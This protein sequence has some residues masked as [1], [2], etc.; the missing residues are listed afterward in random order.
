MVINAHL[1]LEELQRTFSPEQFA[2]IDKILTSLNQT[3]IINV[4]SDRH[5]LGRIHHAMNLDKYSNNEFRKKLFESLPPNI[6]QNYFKKCKI[7][8]YYSNDE[9]IK[10]V[11][12]FEWGDNLSTKNFIEFF[13]YPNYMIPVTSTKIKSNPL[14]MLFEYQSKIVFDTLNNIEYP[15]SNMLIQMP[16]GTGK[17]RTAIEIICRLFNQN[18]DLQIVWFANNEE[19]LDQAHDTFIDVWN[20]VGLFNDLDIKKFWGNNNIQIVPEKKCVLFAGFQKFH[21]QEHLELCPDYIFVDE[22]HK[23]LAPTYEKIIDDNLNFQKQTRI[24]GLT[25]TPGRGINKEENRRLVDRFNGDIIGI[26]LPE[27]Y[28]DT[29]EDNIIEYLEDQHILAK[30]NCI[31]LKTQFEL[32]LSREEQDYLTGIIKDDF[33]EFSE[34]ILARLATDIP[35]NMLIIDELKKHVNDGKKILYFSS[36]LEQSKLI[37]GILQ[38]L[39]IKAVHIDASTDKKFRKQIISKFK[40]TNQ[41]DIISNYDIFSTGFDV[42]NLDLVFIARPVNSPVLFN[43]MIGRGTRGI[44]MGGKEEFTLVQVIDKIKANFGDFDPYAQYR[45]WD[46]DWQ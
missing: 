13:E 1:P 12:E 21:R 18:H 9:K 2:N 30:A 37:T 4:L 44:K 40:E 29:Y 41:I 39:N 28:I 46:T 26:S 43:Q 8:E 17:T 32:V 3:K 11:N 35:R 20:H 34:D 22:A 19:L 23:I 33:P 7:P 15:R 24:I 36:N 25:A 27:K 38:E 42:P 14:K 45:F 10:K 6:I 16:T 5:A 31:P